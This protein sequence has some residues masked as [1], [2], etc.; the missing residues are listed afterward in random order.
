[1]TGGK[2]VAESAEMRLRSEFNGTR[3]TDLSLSA[4]ELLKPSLYLAVRQFGRHLCPARNPRRTLR[5]GRRLLSRVASCVLEVQPTEPVK[6]NFFPKLSVGIGSCCT[7]ISNLM[8]TPAV[9]SKVFFFFRK[10]R[11]VAEKKKAK[12]A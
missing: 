3:L 4:V 10:R 2:T 6:M 8:M 7:A 1:M 12:N 5:A 9:V 11:N